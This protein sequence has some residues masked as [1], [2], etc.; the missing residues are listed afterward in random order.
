[1]NKPLQNTSNL[2]CDCKVKDPCTFTQH[3]RIITRCLECGGIIE[4]NEL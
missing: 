3:G 4:T 2:L 1:M